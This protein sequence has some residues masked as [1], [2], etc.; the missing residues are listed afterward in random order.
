MVM[1]ALPG[2]ALALDPGDSITLNPPTP[3]TGSTIYAGYPF[4]FSGGGTIDGNVDNG[5]DTEVIYAPAGA[6]FVASGCP[7]DYNVAAM[8]IDEQFGGALAI[9]THETSGTGP[10]LSPAGPYRYTAGVNGDVLPTVTNA[11]QYVAC[12][13]LNDLGD[14]TTYAY[15]PTPVTFT[16]SLP[17]GAGQPPQ[18]F[19]GPSGK[20]T[21]AQLGLTVVPANPPLRAPGDN[22]LEIS[23]H[24]DPSN[25][26]VS[27]AVTVKDAGNF[28]GCAA[29]EEQDEQI[30]S[31]DHGVILTYAQAVTINSAGTFRSP[32]AVNFKKAASGT[33]VFCVYLVAEPGSDVARGYYRQTFSASTVHKKPKKHKKLKKRKKHHTASKPK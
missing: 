32:I 11:G 1:A 24:S 7:S 28:N 30:T 13:Y 33:A 18:G 20:P 23:G 3:A 2:T 15:T 31:A 26:P 22:L 21:S 12:A 27:L 10:L 14:D 4:S 25:G 8:A 17:P 19:G 6:A 5:Y 9:Y 16:V 29:N